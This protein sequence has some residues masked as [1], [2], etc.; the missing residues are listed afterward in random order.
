[1]CLSRQIEFEFGKQA[2]ITRSQIRWKLGMWKNIHL[3]RLK[4]LRHN[5]C[6]MGGSIIMQKAQVLESYFRAASLEVCLQLFQNNI[7]IECSCD[8]SALWTGN[9]ITGPLL[10]KKT[11]YNT[12]L[13]VGCQLK[14]AFNF[15][16]KREKKK[17]IFQNAP[18]MV[19]SFGTCNCITRPLLS[20][21]ITYNTF[22]TERCLLA[23]LGPTAVLFAHTLLGHLHF[24]SK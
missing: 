7:F 5:A 21:K 9:C 17:P 14:C 6:L 11:S 8:S 4:K 24:G 23:I 19:L 1:M 2:I 16:N 3:V 15:L 22:L 10:S 12:F 13:T 20:K 18:V